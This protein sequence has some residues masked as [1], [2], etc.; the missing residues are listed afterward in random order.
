VILL[1]THAAVWLLTDRGLGKKSQRI[2]DR[3]LAEDR[4]AVSAFSFWELA[5]L[6]AKRRLRS[7][8][9]ATELRARLLAGGMRELPLTG[10]IGILAAELEG[11]NGDPADRIIVATAIA[12]D[13]TLM[14][15]DE[16]LLRWRNR[17]KRQ[18]AEQ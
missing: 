10:E 1:D 16:N 5:M 6:V 17:L 7:T 3:A 2:V 4:L 14:T 18:D 15:A 9:S 11:L 8:K 13:A 12:H